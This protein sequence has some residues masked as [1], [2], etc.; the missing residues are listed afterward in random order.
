MEAENWLHFGTAENQM[1]M[2]SHGIAPAWGHWCNPVSFPFCGDVSSSP[3]K[4]AFVLFR[5]SSAAAFPG[6]AVCR[7]K[8]TSHWL[9]LRS[10]SEVHLSKNSSLGLSDLRFPSRTLFVGDPGQGA[11]LG[12][13]NA[14]R[15]L[16][17]GDFPN[18]ISMELTAAR[19]GACLHWG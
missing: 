1:R 2:S 13:V 7:Y 6:W 12:A 10:P 8:E 16:A 14:P 5:T 11:A 4:W 3:L 15:H 19:R 17:P 9:M 18:F